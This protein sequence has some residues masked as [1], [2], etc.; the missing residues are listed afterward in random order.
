MTLLFWMICFVIFFHYI[1]FP[2]ITILRA[3]VVNLVVEKQSSFPYVTLVIA[4]YNEEKIIRE[5]IENCFALDYPKDKL[6]IIIV[7]DGSTDKTPEIVSE[8]SEQGIISLFSPPRKGKTSALNRAVAKASGEIVVFS[9][10]NSMYKTDAITQ[11]V[12]NFSEPSIGGVCGRKSI[13]KSDTRE[14]S[15]GDSLFWQLESFLKIQQS[16]GG[17]ITTGDGEIFAIRR[18]LYQT[19]PEEIINDD[20]AITFQIIEKGYRVVYE[21]DAVSAEEA[22][23]VLKDDFNVK[24]RMVSGGYQ[25]LQYYGRVIFPP[26]SFFAVQFFSHKVLRWT[27]PLWL[28][29][30]MIVNVCLLEGF[31]F[32]FFC[33]QASFYFLALAGFLLKRTGRN[34]NIV[35]Y[36]PL[37][38]CTM[39][40]AACKG[41]IAF[42]TN[43]SQVNIW[44]KAAR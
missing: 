36:I 10:A 14:S 17:S 37:Y 31:Y 19:I 16:R 29:T 33:L 6:E 26:R 35:F 9:D 12:A 23:I 32:A 28:I 27:M 34:I 38:F 24:V 20:T 43:E 30:L 11:L 8:F 15:T 21:P 18:E 44:K 4:A 2:L 22:S 5:K 39:N 41:L 42:L 13:V 3:A 1:L 7:S 25:T 40:F